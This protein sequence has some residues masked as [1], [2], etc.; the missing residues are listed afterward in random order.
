MIPE[1]SPLGAVIALNHEHGVSVVSLTGEHDLTTKEQLRDTLD[2]LLHREPHPNNAPAH[3]IIDLS[4]TRFIDSSTITTILQ[5]H[6]KAQND[7]YTHLVLVASPDSTPDRVLRLI[8]VDHVIPTYPHRAA[9]LAALR[10]ASA[11]TTNPNPTA[12]P[13]PGGAGSDNGAPRL[14]R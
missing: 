7:P 2:G 8:H 9:A 14:S 13:L 10:A 12:V 6:H 3:V 4:N 1:E 11:S 5:A